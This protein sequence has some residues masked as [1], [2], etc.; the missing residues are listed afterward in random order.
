V[1]P[2][3]PEP[4]P[5]VNADV[6]AEAAE[7]RDAFLELMADPAVTYRVD[8]KVEIGADGQG[9]PAITLRGQYDVSGDDYAG[10]ASS[11]AAAVETAVGN[12]YIV[13]VDGSTHASE[14][15]ETWTTVD[16]AQ[17]GHRPTAV[18]EIVANDLVFRGRTE[19]G[20]FEFDVRPWVFGDPVS[21]WSALGGFGEADVPAAPMDSH[22]TR[23]LLD[24]H[25][26]PVQLSSSWTFSTE[27]D[28]ERAAGSV[29]HRFSSF[30]LYVSI[31][32]NFEEAW[33]RGTSHDISVGVDDTN[34]VV[35]EPWFD[36]AP[37]AGDPTAELA[38]SLQAP[39]DLMLGIEGAVLFLA[40]HDAGGSLVLDAIV[41][42]EG[43]MVEAPT[44][45]QTLEAYYRTCSGNCALL[46]P[47]HTFCTVEADLD[48]GTR[49]HL[50]VAI[51]DPEQA[52]CSLSPSADG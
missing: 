9:G 14:S 13:G 22:R 30:G 21:T 7:V 27:E 28:A 38:V 18:G 15:F 44:G 8:S 24:G 1:A 35:R 6:Q 20:F 31:P 42:F 52:D 4:Q 32:E 36:V 25:G 29:L 12:L 3:T 10:Y 50:T 11:S 40:S 41:P 37:N 46:D 47:P 23:L 17:A 33:A 5:S 19:D 49:Y 34:T 45:H 43:G 48:A 16:G 26:I 39:D 51:T 2:L